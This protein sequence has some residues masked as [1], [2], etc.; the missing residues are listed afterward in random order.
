M[1]LVDVLEEHLNEVEFRWLQWESSLEAADVTLEEAA[2]RGERL[3]AHLEGLE[4]TSALDAVLRPAFDPEEATRVLAA[5]RAPLELCH[6]DEVLMLL[7]GADAPTR[8]AILRALEVRGGP[9]LAPDLLELLKLEDAALQTG[10]LEA[11]VR[12]FTH[13]EAICP[14]RTWPA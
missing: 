4:D 5:T 14:G 13:D 9:G 2:T 6:V 8:A 7:R 11:L 10:V 12:F 3:L 1:F